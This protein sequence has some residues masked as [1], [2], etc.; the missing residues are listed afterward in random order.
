MSVLRLIATLQC[1]MLTASHVM[2]HTGMGA[3]S[4]LLTPKAACGIRPQGRQGVGFM[5]S[6]S[7][8]WE[9]DTM[10]QRMTA[11]YAVPKKKPS[12]R[13]TRIRKTAWMKRYPIN[14]K[15]PMMLDMFD[16]VKY[17]DGTLTKARTTHQGWL[18]L[19]NT[20]LEGEHFLTKEVRP[21]W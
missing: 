9:P 3:G 12:K 5:C 21:R 1:W 19:P 20:S 16:I 11:L 18:N 2:C 6:Y 15:R 10:S 14:W 8:T 13:R 7:G 17:T 4:R